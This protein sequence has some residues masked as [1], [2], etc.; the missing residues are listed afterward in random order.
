MNDEMKAALAPRKVKVYTFLTSIERAEAQTMARSRQTTLSEW[1]RMLIVAALT[2]ANLGPP[3]SK[4]SIVS[5]L[6][7]AKDLLKDYVIGDIHE[8]DES[9]Q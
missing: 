5:A 3:Q 9:E 2:P 1:I 7:Q 6:P 4:Q 8:S